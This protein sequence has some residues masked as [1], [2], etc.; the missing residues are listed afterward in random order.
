MNGIKGK[1]VQTSS[2]HLK[3]AVID[4]MF[5]GFSG[6]VKGQE[7]YAITGLGAIATK[8]KGAGD[9]AK[10]GALAGAGNAGEKIADY[11]IKLAENIASKCGFRAAVEAS[12]LKAKVEELAYGVSQLEQYLSC[13]IHGDCFKI[14]IC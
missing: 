14:K 12:D 10:E 5:S 6:S 11:Y 4:S 7:Q 9:L 3:N 8:H 2:Q 13:M 1:V